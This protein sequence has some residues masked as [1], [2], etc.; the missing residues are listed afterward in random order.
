M[1]QSVRS[2]LLLIALAGITATLAEAAVP[3]GYVDF[4]KIPA[5]AAGGQFVEVN[6]NSNI[7][8]MVA[9]LTQKNEPDVADMIQGLKGIRVN[10]IGVDDENREEVESRVKAI[11]EQLNS[12]GWDR[13]V[14]A[15]DKKQDVGVYLKT[16]GPE[17]V[18]GVVVTVLDGKKQAVLINVVGDINID[19]LGLLGEKF[20]IDPLK[21]IGKSVKPH[22]NH[23]HQPAEEEAPAKEAPEKQ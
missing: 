21:K 7:I 10:V 1:K 18:E 4:G 2:T 17:A 9:K 5:P 14:T 13:V 6:V 3:A 11:R 22:Q 23:R 15:Q 19:K 12:N 20:N 16:R 8:A